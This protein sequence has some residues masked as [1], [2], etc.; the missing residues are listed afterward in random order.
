MGSGIPEDPFVDLM[1]ALNL[2][3]DPGPASYAFLLIPSETE[4]FQLWEGAEETYNT[5]F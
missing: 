3:A 4:T 5:P 1:Y 2:M